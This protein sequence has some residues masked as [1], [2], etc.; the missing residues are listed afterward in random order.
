MS[1]ASSSIVRTRLGLPRPA[2]LWPRRSCRRWAARRRCRTRSSRPRKRR[3]WRGSR[4]FP[5][6]IQLTHRPRPAV[7]RRPGDLRR[8]DHPRRDQRGDAAAWPT[9]SCVRRDG[10]DLLPG[11][12]RRDDL[13]GRLRRQD[14]STVPVKVAQ[15]TVQPPISFR[16]DVMPVFMRSGCN[17]GSCHGAARGKDGFRLSLFGFDPEGDHFRLTREMVRPPDQPGRPA[18]STLLE[19]ATGAVPHT[20]GKRFEAEQRAL[21]DAPRLDRGRRAQRRRQPSCP[22]SWAS[23]SIPS[24]PCSTARARPSSSPC[25]RATPTAPTAT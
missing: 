18:D 15:A 8:R 14:R 7:D 19:K 24:R 22:R 25:G 10:A 12:R 6:T 4:S 11:G 21:P 13:D 3:R 2:R 9:R 17:T 23:T 5:P 16:L 1:H 20:G